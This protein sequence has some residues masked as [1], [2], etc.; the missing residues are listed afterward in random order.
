MVLLDTK[1]DNHVKKDNQNSRP[2]QGQFKEF[3]PYLYQVKVK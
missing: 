2:G 3:Y 1:K